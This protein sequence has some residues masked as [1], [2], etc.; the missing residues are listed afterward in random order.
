MLALSGVA[1]HRGTVEQEKVQCR[2]TVNDGAG[3]RAGAR[4]GEVIVDAWSREQQVFRLLLKF[5][6]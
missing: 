1:G 5:D 6:L 3:Y 4:A 2:A